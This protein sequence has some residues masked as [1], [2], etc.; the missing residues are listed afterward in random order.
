M[1]FRSGEKLARAVGVIS[2]ELEVVMGNKLLKAGYKEIKA[3][4]Q[5]EAELIKAGQP[6]I[7]AWVARAKKIGV[8]GNKVISDFIKVAGM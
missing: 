1:L 4:K 3:S 2:D 5:F 8:D 6:Q 7:D